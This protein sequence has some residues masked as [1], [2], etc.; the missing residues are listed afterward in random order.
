MLT[1]AINGLVGDHMVAL[2]ND[3]AVPMALYTSTLHDEDPHAQLLLDD[4]A[5]AVTDHPERDLSHV[6]LFVHGLGET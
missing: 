4:I 6:V 1:G 3:L 5:A 2:D